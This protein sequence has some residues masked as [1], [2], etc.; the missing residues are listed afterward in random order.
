M[1]VMHLLLCQLYLTMQ[2]RKLLIPGAFRNEQRRGSCTARGA[3][4][5]RRCR[6]GLRDGCH[7][8]TYKPA[9]V[10]GFMLVVHCEVILVY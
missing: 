7:P 10:Q 1:W 9:L 6:R 3:T 2:G 5:V 4:R 8:E